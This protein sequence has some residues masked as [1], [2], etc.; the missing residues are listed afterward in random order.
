M[1]AFE[2][3]YQN[4]V[5]AARNEEVSRI[6][7]YE[8]IV[9][10]GKI[11]EI[12]GKDLNALFQGDDA[13]L[14]EFFHDYCL[15]FKD[16][17]YDVVPFECCIG[18]VM[19][20]SGALGDSRVDPVIKKMTDFQQYPWEEIPELYFQKNSRYFDALERQMPQGMKA[21]GGVGNGVFECVQEL[22]GYQ[23]L[24]YLSVDDEELYAGLFNQVGKISLVIWKRFMERYHD[25]YCVLRFGDDLGY[26]STTLLSPNDTRTHIIPKYKP[27]IDLVH[28]Y[29]K[30]FLLHSCG[31]IFDVM[32]DLL[33]A[34]IDAKHSN[35]DQIAPFPEWVRRYGDKIGNFG[36]IDVDVV[37]NYG[38]E[39]LREYIAD[40]FRQCRGHGGFAFGTGN[41]IPD[42][43]PAEGYMNM[44]EIARELRGD[45]K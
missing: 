22:V 33:A 20:G 42:Y 34:G 43:V 3:D 39:E 9:S 1:K 6:P 40:I 16:N 37:C 31:K 35:E 25:L 19:P 14:D 28:S 23:N 2:P 11:G 41:S 15:F 29:H 12:I 32:P 44:I 21:V 38:K 18:P 13:D 30:P 5:K 24:C 45:Y 26:K 17:G 27:V 4:I 7:L 10:F 8:H 36:G